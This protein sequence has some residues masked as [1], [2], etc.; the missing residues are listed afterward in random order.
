MI[1]GNAVGMEL[2]PRLDRKKFDGDQRLLMHGLEIIAAYHGRD[3]IL[4]G[5]SQGRSV[6]LKEF[7]DLWNRCATRS[8][9]LDYTFDS[10]MRE[11]KIDI[12]WIEEWHSHG[13]E[14]KSSIPLSIFVDVVR[15]RFNQNLT[16]YYLLK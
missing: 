13:S 7:K 12:L 9:K 3:E 2:P 4:L 8:A 11:T 5:S 1:V 16:A 14:H 10:Y 15:D 6:F